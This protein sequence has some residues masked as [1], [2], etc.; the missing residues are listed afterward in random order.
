MQ[1]GER[2]KVPAPQGPCTQPV[3]IFDAE[4]K[5][6]GFCHIPVPHLLYFE[7]S[8]G[9]HL[10]VDPLLSPLSLAFPSLAWP[11][12]TEYLTTP[13]NWCPKLY[14]LRV[15]DVTSYLTKV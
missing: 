2:R 10:P 7:Q 14:R 11:E 3:K 15:E 5:T 9:L 13:F 6:F 1:L 4:L 8:S 12:R